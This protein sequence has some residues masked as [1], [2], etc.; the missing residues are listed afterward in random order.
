MPACGQIEEFDRLCGICVDEAG[1][2]AFSSRADTLDE[3]VIHADE[4]VETIAQHFADGRDAA[5]VGAGFFY[6]VKV[7]VLRGEFSDLLG[8]EVGFVGDGIVVEHAGERGRGDDGG[9]V[10]RISRQSEV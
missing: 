6:R 10:A 7:L 2:P 8:Q 3:N 4:Y 1:D 5:N 9:D